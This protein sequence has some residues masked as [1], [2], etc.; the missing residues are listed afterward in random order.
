MVSIFIQIFENIIIY[1]SI[2][3][4]CCL[5]EVHLNSSIKRFTVYDGIKLEIY[6]ALEYTLYSQSD[7]EVTWYKHIGINFGHKMNWKLLMNG[8]NLFINWKQR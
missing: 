2:E 1:G 5:K 6:R 8:G 7:S 3:V 4:V